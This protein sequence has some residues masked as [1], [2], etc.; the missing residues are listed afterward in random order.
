[1]SASYVLW[2]KCIFGSGHGPSL[3][4]GLLS[5]VASAMKP[6]CLKNGQDFK[7]RIAFPENQR[8]FYKKNCCYF[9]ILQHCLYLIA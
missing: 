4:L 8:L 3:K 5:F 6:F 7:K 1:V 2:V 9:D